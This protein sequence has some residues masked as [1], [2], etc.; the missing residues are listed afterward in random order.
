M[1]INVFGFVLVWETA[2][3][4]AHEEIQEEERGKFL[5]KRIFRKFFGSEGGKRGNGD[6][7]E[8]IEADSTTT[9][10]TS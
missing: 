2:K 1:M 10:K 3:S 4:V 5:S 7:V 6:T 9:E 8:L